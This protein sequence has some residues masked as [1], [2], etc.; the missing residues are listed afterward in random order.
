MF[1]ESNQR[2]GE[3]KPPVP[4]RKFQ[5]LVGHQSAGL[6]TGLRVASPGCGYAEA[7]SRARV[8]K[9]TRGLTAQSYQLVLCVKHLGKL[10][11]EADGR[12][13]SRLEIVSQAPIQSRTHS[14][15]HERCLCQSA[16]FILACSLID[17]WCSMALHF[18]ASH[19]KRS[20]A[21]VRLYT[22]RSTQ[23]CLQCVGSGQSTQ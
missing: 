14:S 18:H 11:L 8:A 7:P 16:C 5:K 10:S 22:H 6:G 20:F 2:L 21:T 3:G 17:A 4:T 12:I 9:A 15:Q 23:P 13:Q 19:V 1:K